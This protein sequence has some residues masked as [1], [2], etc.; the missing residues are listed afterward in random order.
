MAYCLYPSAKLGALGAQARLLRMPPHSHA[1][2]SPCLLHNWHKMLCK[3]WH[4]SSGHSA[5][6]SM[7]RHPCPRLSNTHASFFRGPFTRSP[8]T[9]PS[10]RPLTLPIHPALL[11]THSPQGQALLQPPPPQARACAQS[12][13][14]QGSTRAAAPPASLLGSH[15]RHTSSCAPPRPAGRSAAPPAGT[16]GGAT[17]ERK[18]WGQMRAA[19]T[20]VCALL[21]VQPLHL[22]GCLEEQQW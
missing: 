16:L 9:T 8:T 22:S 6:C 17:V 14:A 12:S 1:F 7:A 4:H 21:I 18:G 10:N 19:H 5:A 13:P 20:A 15:T 11:P 2:D 3:S